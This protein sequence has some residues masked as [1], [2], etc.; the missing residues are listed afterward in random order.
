MKSLFKHLPMILTVCIVG[1]FLLTGCNSQSVEPM[2]DKKIIST[3]A[4]AT[5]QEAESYSIGWKET[6][7]FSSYNWARSISPDLN[8]GSTH[9]GR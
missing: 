3:N 6:E 9:E 1:C 4:N 7:P 8:H 2:P 5:I